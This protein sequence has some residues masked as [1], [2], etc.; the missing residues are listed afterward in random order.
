MTDKP[1]NQDPFRSPGSRYEHVEV[2]VVALVPG[3]QPFD[4]SQ[5][6]ISALW[7]PEDFFAVFYQT[8]KALS[9]PLTSRL[10]SLYAQYRFP[11]DEMRSLADELSLI[12]AHV[13]PPVSEA[14]RLA[15]ELVLDGLCSLEPV[16]VLIEGP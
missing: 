13:D 2:F 14:V 4:W 12:S 9:F 5:D 6:A 8:A 10:T 11:R 7:L 15:A 16:D 3:G 1:T